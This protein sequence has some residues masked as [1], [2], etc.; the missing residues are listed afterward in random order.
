LYIYVYEQSINAENFRLCK[1][2]AHKRPWS[3]FGRF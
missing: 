1:C 2:Y 3:T